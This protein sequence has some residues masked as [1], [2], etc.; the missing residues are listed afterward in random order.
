MDLMVVAQKGPALFGRDGLLQFQVNWHEIKVLKLQQSTQKTDA[1]LKEILDKHKAVFGSEIG[2]L[3]GITATL[4]LE[5]NARPK[6]CKARLVPYSLKPK[7]EEELQRLEKEGIIK[8]VTH[9]KWASQVVPVV[10][11]NRQVRLCGDYKVTI[12]PV[13]KVDQY[14]LPRIQDI[15][16]SLAGGKKNLKIDLTQ[17]Y[18]KME[19]DEATRELMTINTQKGLYQ[20]T[21]LQFGVAAAPAIW[22]RAIEQV[23]QWVPFTSCVLDDMIISWKTDEEHLANLEAVLERLEKFGLRANLNKCAFF[24]EQV[25]YCGHMISEEGLKK[26]PDKVNAVLKA[27]RPENLQQL[28]SFLGLVNYYHSFLSNLST[29]LGPLNELLQGEKTWKWTKRCEQAVSEVK[30]LMT[31]GQVLCYYDHTS[32]SS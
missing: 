16:A 26:S 6:F 9:S 28:R 27:P 25:S 32:L 3:K 12:N 10:K 11:K 22:Q 20:Y 19:V 14:P 7:V 24:Q 29:V 2:K 4:Y 13:M 23:L 15:F 8:P 5:D 1:V 31:S 17:A 30:E 21:R 18:N